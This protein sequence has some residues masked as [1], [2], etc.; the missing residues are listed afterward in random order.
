MGNRKKIYC[1]LCKGYLT[2][3]DGRGTI[4]LISNCKKCNKRIVYNP[5]LDS[6][7]VKEIPPRNTSSGMTFY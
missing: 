5:E 7:D 4:N 1:P 2:T 3:Y 6:I